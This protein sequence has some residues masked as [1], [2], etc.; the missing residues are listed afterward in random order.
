MPRLTKVQKANS[1]NIN[2][3]WKRPREDVLIDENN[4]FQEVDLDLVDEQNIEQLNTTEV[5]GLEKSIQTENLRF[6]KSTQVITNC[7]NHVSHNETKF[8]QW[9]NDDLI[10]DAFDVLK[11]SCDSW[12]STQ[13]RT[14]SVII[15]MILKSANLKWNFIENVLKNLNCLNIKHAHSWF[16]TI[17]QDGVS[18]LLEDERGKYKREE[19]YNMYPEIKTAAYSYALENANK[20]AATFTVSTL[21]NFVSKEFEKLNEISLKPGELIRSV[22][23]CNVDL[24]KWGARWD[25]NKNRPYFEGHEREDVVEARK[26]FVRY[27]LDNKELYFTETLGPIRSWKRPIRNEIKGKPRIL[28][29]HDESTFKSGEV[30]SKRWIFPESAPL[31][32]KG[33]GR[34]MMLSFFTVCSDESS[35]FQLSESEWNEAVKFQ[36]ELNDDGNMNFFPRSASAWIEP[37]KDNYFNNEDILFQFKRLFLLLKYKKGYENF[38]I[39]ILVDNSR[40]H[41]TKLY[42]LN[43]INKNPSMNLSI[44]ETIEYEEND[45]KKIIQCNFVDEHGLKKSKGLFIIAKELG[46]IE[47]DAEPKDKRYLLNN[48]K[49]ILSGHIAFKS[50]TKLEK[51]SLENGFKIIFVPKFHCELNPIEGLWCFMKRYVRTRTDQN[52]DTMKRLIF[53]SIDKYNKD[54]ENKNLNRKLWNRFWKCIDMY[55]EGETYA[56]V[57]QSLFGAKQSGTIKNHKTNKNFNTLI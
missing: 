25:D 57:L 26:N 51:L 2:S 35:I 39:E 49:E 54:P 21:A 9:L 41:S 18:S 24:I 32:N 6:D 34:S 17:I 15:Y 10:S 5:I 23:S 56:T 19:F 1:D 52:F 30:A 55:Q 8:I 22:S 37:G 47:T 33:R 29:S 44:Y 50:I 4:N 48:L 13:D 31:F 3:R 53:E 28:I 11:D 36:P 43:N 14:F 40:T 45:E 27:F 38:D 20:K 16:K 46:L 7:C 12:N 42:D